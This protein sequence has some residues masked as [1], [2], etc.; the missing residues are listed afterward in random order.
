MSNLEV[1]FNNHN[2][3]L[4]FPWSI[5][6]QPL[7]NDLNLFLDTFVKPG[8]SVL[9]IG[10]GDFQEFDLIHNKVAK[11]SVLDIDSRV[12]ETLEKR[13]GNSICEYFLVDGEFNGY[14][15][16]KK[17]DV[18]YAKEVI[19][20]IIDYKRFLAHL[21]TMLKDDGGMWIS[22]PNYGFFLLPLLEVTILEVIARISGFSRKNIHPSKFTE[23][24]FLSAAKE[25]GFYEIIV[26]ETPFRLALIMT[27]GKSA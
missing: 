23:A 27:L 7:I 25:A 10:P 11:V 21:N 16:T 1:Y 19:E 18:I 3:A 2:K 9:V 14:P 17:F 6:H 20:H 4:R 24:S 8:S 13:H 26:K 12:I 15:L 22:T 5:Y